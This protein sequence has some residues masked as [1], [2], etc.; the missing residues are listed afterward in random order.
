VW[1]EQRAKEWLA[2]PSSW[3]HE[4]M[5]IWPEFGHALWA[6]RNDLR[7]IKPHPLPQR[8]HHHGPSEPHR[9][10]KG[11]LKL[12]ESHAEL[13]PCLGLSFYPEIDH[14]PIPHAFTLGGAD[15]TV[16]V[17]L[18]ADRIHNRDGYMAAIPSVPVLS[19]LARSTRLYL[20]DALMDRME[21]ERDPL[22]HLRR[23]AEA[24]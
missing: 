18:S 5:T 24:V 17:D 3:K 13:L 20:S 21:R 8:Y 2:D 22:A 11:A 9:C 14:P 12:A 6:I 4:V 1:N 7:W 23:R 10:V 15:R 19:M 16:A